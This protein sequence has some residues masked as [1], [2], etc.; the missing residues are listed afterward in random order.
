MRETSEK[1]QC[2]RWDAGSSAHQAWKHC[3]SS[4]RSA[5][6]TGH[7]VGRTEGTKEWEFISDVSIWEMTP[8]EKLSMLQRDDK[9]EEIS[10]GFWKFLEKCDKLTRLVWCTEASSHLNPTKSHLIRAKDAPAIQP[11]GIE[12]LC[13][14][15]QGQRLSF[16]RKNVPS[17]FIT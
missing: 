17:T 15:N 2:P 10:C 16:K 1:L 9:K 4:E 12:E 8:T 6:N 7:R 3:Q 5:L 11:P 13:V 14:K